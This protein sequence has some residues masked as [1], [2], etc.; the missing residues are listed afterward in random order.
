MGWDSCSTWTKKEDVI[1]DLLRQF[2]R[3]E[4]KVHA[5]KSVKEGAWFVVENTS[6]AKFIYLALINKHGSEYAV[7]TMTEHSGPYHFSCPVAFLNIADA[8]AP[9]E[10]H[11]IKWRRKLLEATEL[12][13]RKLVPG[14][15]IMLY[16]NVYS[17]VAPNK[18][19]FTVRCENGKLYKLT[20]KQMSEWRYT[21]KL[22]ELLE[23]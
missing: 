7:K 4:W 3:S 21:T 6:G 5:K 13:N 11:A 17:V 20:K 23:A 8:P 15:N 22:G 1:N 10:T 19:S 9:S 16:G 14:M 18:N 2:S 12:K